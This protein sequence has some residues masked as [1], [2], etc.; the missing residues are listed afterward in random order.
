MLMPDE[1]LQDLA[2]RV[3]GLPPTMLDARLLAEYTRAGK[4]YDLSELCHKSGVSLRQVALLVIVGGVDDVASLPG[5]A[6]TREIFDIAENIYSVGETRREWQRIRN[7]HKPAVLESQKSRNELRRLEAD[8]AAMRKHY[9]RI[10]FKSW[11]AFWDD[12][13]LCRMIDK[14][15][16]RLIASVPLELLTDR[17]CFAAVAKTGMALRFVPERLRSLVICARAVENDSAAIAFTPSRFRDEI[18]KLND[19]SY[20]PG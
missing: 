4:A 5:Y 14:L 9:A 17:V 15:D 16:G 13:F 19:T 10:F 20:K 2:G 11:A 7:R 12:D 1:H 18:R 8:P 3:R 6:V